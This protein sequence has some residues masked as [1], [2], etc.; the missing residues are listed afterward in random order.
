MKLLKANPQERLGTKYGASELKQHSWFKHVNFAMLYSPPIRIEPKT[1]FEYF[2]AIPR[3]AEQ[4]AKDFAGT[5]FQL[6]KK[7]EALVG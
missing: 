4:I 1:V 6:P 3:E 5:G 7:A 2:R